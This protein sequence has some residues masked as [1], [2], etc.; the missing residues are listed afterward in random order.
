MPKLFIIAGC[1]G[2]G[3]TTASFT[4]L[5]EILNCHEFVNADIIA[6]GLSPFAPEKAAVAAGRILLERVKELMESGKDFAIETTL[7]TRTHVKMI[8]EAQERGYIV[9]ILFFW[10]NMPSLA[11]E[12]VRL[13][14]QSGGHNVSEDKIR[15]RYDMGIIHLFQLYLPICDYWIIIDNSNAPMII[16]E[17]GKDITTKIHNK[18]LFN[19]LIN[20][21]RTRITGA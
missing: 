2:A 19:Q 21:E 6:K 4:I 13:R 7:A 15:R 3:K 9:T 10:L 11:I 16:S 17:G 5:P 20:Y 18:T 12:R 14:V 1:N 8:K